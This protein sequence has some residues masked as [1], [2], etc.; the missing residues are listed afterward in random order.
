MLEYMIGIM[1]EEGRPRRYLRIKSDKEIAVLD[2][3][4]TFTREQQ[5]KRS[6]YECIVGDVLREAQE[7]GFYYVWFS[8]E[9]ALIETD[10]TV[11][12][13]EEVGELAPA[14]AAASI[15]FVSLAESGGIDEGTAREY[16]GLFS[17][18]EW[19]IDYAVGNIRSYEGRL[20]K[21]VQ[22]HTSAEDWT[23]PATPA[24]W[25]EIADPA[26]E[27]P[28]WSQPIGAHDAY[29]KGDK[30]SHGGG[31]WVS[32]VDANVWEPGVYGWEE[33]TGETEAA[34][35]SAR[36][37]VDLD[38][39]TVAQLKEYARENGIDISGKTLKADIIAAIKAAD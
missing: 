27:W 13:A 10:H 30:V 6:V 32:T 15:A 1:R 17:P 12:L 28:G 4:V 26:E 21:C 2:G 37:A 39:M 19:P 5:E 35:Y 36:A 20:Y 16:A 31:K 38:A 3:V 23:P 11:Q 9:S 34:S 7:G 8:L 29:N 18:W 24:I 33:Y 14:A 22:A 25:T